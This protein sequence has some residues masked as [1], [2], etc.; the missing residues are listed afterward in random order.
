[1]RT[2]AIVAGCSYCFSMVLVNL[3]SLRRNTSM[4]SCLK[5]SRRIGRPAQPRLAAIAARSSQT[6]ARERMRGSLSGAGQAAPVHADTA[7]FVANAATQASV[8]R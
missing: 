2:A 3:F 1:M 8:N 6:S 7:R 5:T 4:P